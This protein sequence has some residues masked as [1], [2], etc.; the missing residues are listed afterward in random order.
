M[1]AWPFFH[2]VRFAN[3]QAASTFGLVDPAAKPLP[4]SSSGLA[5]RPLRVAI[6]EQCTYGG[7]IYEAHPILIGMALTGLETRAAPV[8]AVENRRVRVAPIDLCQAAHKPACAAC[9]S[10]YT[11]NVF[12]IFSWTHTI[13]SSRPPSTASRSL[14]K[15][16]L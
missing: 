7:T 16:L 4:S 14:G 15:M 2:C 6:I 3:S 11:D 10:T 8:T 5:K 9:A 12:D 1:S 13:P